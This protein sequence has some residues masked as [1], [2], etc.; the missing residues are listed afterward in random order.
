MFWQAI[1]PDKKLWIGGLL[2]MVRDLML[3]S[4]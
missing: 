4:S 2:G 3:W 1:T